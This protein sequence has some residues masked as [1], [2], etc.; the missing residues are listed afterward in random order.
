MCVNAKSH[1]MTFA[2]VMCDMYIGLDD[3]KGQGLAAQIICLCVLREGLGTS[4]RAK[5]TQL[6]LIRASDAYSIKHM[7]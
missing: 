3:T 5:A 1:S 4:T 6:R 7:P 2:L